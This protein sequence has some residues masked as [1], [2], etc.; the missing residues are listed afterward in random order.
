MFIM[1][2]EIFAQHKVMFALFSFQDEVD[3]PFM[4]FYSSITTTA[5]LSSPSSMI[6]F[7]NVVDDRIQS[8]IGVAK[9]CI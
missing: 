3:H 9:S 2:H 6:A 7:F 4:F 5:I 8:Y 1:A